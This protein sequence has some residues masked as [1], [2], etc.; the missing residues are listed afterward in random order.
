MSLRK[1]T[2]ELLSSK[3]K[4]LHHNNNIERF[5]V[6]RVEFYNEIILVVILIFANSLGM[7]MR[8]ITERLL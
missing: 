4:M 3:N 1:Q 7:S 6:T 8:S 2:F 5:T